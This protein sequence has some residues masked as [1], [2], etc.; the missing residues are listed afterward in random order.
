MA[1]KL[2]I[3]GIISTSEKFKSQI[4]FRA[5]CR[6]ILAMNYPLIINSNDWGT[7]RRILWY[8]CNIRF[9]DAPQLSNE[10]P[11]DRE[12]NKTFIKSRECKEAAQSL[13]VHYYFRLKNEYNGNIHEVPSPTIEAHT[14]EYRISQDTLGRFIKENILITPV[15]T[16]ES[17][18]FRVDLSIITSSY[19]DW[20]KI[21]VQKSA[22][23][24]S[25]ILSDIMSS[26]L[27]KYIRNDPETNI[28]FVSNI[29]PISMSVGTYLAHQRDAAEQPL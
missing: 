15:Q 20:Y 29:R 28:Q 26:K 27:K 13:L 6:Y 18:L 11:V 16:E 8:N 25:I 17:E 1:L 24:P 3:D 23:E 2:L 12:I 4:N 10:R 21:N 22:P 7:W 5:Y 19:V 14:E 9:C